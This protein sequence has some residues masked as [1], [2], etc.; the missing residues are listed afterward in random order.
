MIMSS[1]P[2]QQ[3]R[4]DDTRENKGVTGSIE[5]DMCPVLDS[6]TMP[7]GSSYEGA[8]KPADL[9]DLYETIERYYTKRVTK[10]GATPRGADWRC[11]ATQELRFVQ[12]LKICDFSRPLSLND[13]G[14]GYGALVAYL[15]ERHAGTDVDY[16]GTDLS[17][18]MISRARRRW[19]GHGRRFVVSRA[20]P[21]V[22]DYSVASGIF[23]VKLDQ[24]VD[25]WRSFVADTLH[26][27]HNTSK[28]GFAVNFMSP[29]AAANER[30]TMLYCTAA[31][32]WVH[33]CKQ[34]FR[35]SVD[36][37]ENYGLREFTLLIRF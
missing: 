13:V 22:A 8:R 33:Y 10:H 37:I 19:R 34:Q 23:N 31:E 1:F 12:L 25:T 26:D 5:F 18:A 16:L 15:A 24:P 21:R 17:R 28:R 11:R 7:E 29:A 36:V 27:M 6:I 2:F 14:C 3:R 35:C 4:Q 20:A 9:G 30:S 32:P